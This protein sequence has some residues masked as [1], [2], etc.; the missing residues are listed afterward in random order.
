MDFTQLVTPSPN[1]ASASATLNKTTNKSSG[2]MLP[3]EF[4]AMIQAGLKQARDSQS[5]QGAQTTQSAQSNQNQQTAQAAQHAQALCTLVEPPLESAEL[6]AAQQAAEAAELLETQIK[7]GSELTPEQ[8]E[9]DQQL[10]PAAQQSPA[11]Q[12]QTLPALWETLFR[13]QLDPAEAAE[14]AKQPES[15]NSSAELQPLPV[16]SWS[17]GLQPPSQQVFNQPSNQTTP[18]AFNI[19]VPASSSQSEMTA[20]PVVQ[21]ETDGVNLPDT[22]S[23][24]APVDLPVHLANSSTQPGSENLKFSQSWLDQLKNQLAQSLSFQSQPVANPAQA[25]LLPQLQQQ[26]GLDVFDETISSPAHERALNDAPTIENA[27]QPAGGF[28]LLNGDQAQ[29]QTYTAHGER[30]EWSTQAA[31]ASSTQSTQQAPSEFAERVSLVRQLSD[32]IQLLHAA[33]QRSIELTLNPA[34]LGKVSLRLQQEAQQMHLQ[35]LTELPLAKD[36]LE[37]QLQQLRQQFQ[38]QGLNLHQIQIEVRPD[39]QAFQEQSSGRQ[40]SGQQQAQRQGPEFDLI[41]A[42]SGLSS[43]SPTATV[44]NYLDGAAVNTLA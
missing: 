33:R 21:I 29:S 30:H 12:A 38:Q 5:S 35:I 32:R 16:F 17:A 19:A 8:L 4:L 11:V 23:S 10:N 43:E 15:T 37:S 34:S 7:S 27:S 1:P 26:M 20:I 44:N 36:L 6:L 13:Q 41:G 18:A 3:G 42:L 31:H 24:E 22:Q 39:H 28:D 25:Q 2:E 40:Q 14:A 9:Q